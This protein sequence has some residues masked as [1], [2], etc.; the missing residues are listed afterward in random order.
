MENLVFAVP[1]HR[2]SEQ[3]MRE[4]CGPMSEDKAVE[5]MRS[6]QV[7]MLNFTL[8]GRATTGELRE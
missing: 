4:A 8:R 6:N 5:L 7:S 2:V 3:E 1:E